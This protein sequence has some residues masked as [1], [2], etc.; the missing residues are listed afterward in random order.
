M[1]HPA[2]IKDITSLNGNEQV[3]LGS[4]KLDEYYRVACYPKSN[5]L[6]AAL[7]TSSGEFVLSTSTQS[8]GWSS[9]YFRERLEL[10]AD[11]DEGS[12]SVAFADTRAFA[13]DRRGNLLIME[14]T[15]IIK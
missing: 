5:L 14:L 15:N 13:L 1:A 3:V 10:V 11:R 9:F 12:C 6:A 4:H 2:I 7:I 8:T